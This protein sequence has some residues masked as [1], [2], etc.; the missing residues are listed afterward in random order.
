[1]SL[2]QPPNLTWQNDQNP[3]SH[4][5]LVPRDSQLVGAPV[6]TFVV[7]CQSISHL[8]TGKAN[9]ASSQLGA[10]GCTPAL[11]VADHLHSCRG[12]KRDSVPQTVVCRTELDAFNPAPPFPQ[13][14][15]QS[16]SRK[17]NPPAPLY[18][19]YRCRKGAPSPQTASLRC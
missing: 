9:T 8:Q 6:Q 15:Y 18:G 12:R 4:M 14:P 3:S 2:L 17:S 16:S 13:G 10:W 11:E 1:M 19:S 7:P 5:H